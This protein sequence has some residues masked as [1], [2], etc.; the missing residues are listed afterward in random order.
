M[1]FGTII[2]CLMG[3]SIAGSA[4][5]DSAATGDSV[6]QLASSWKDQ[7]G[8][9]LQLGKFQG[10]PLIL[11]MIYT[12]CKDTC[13]LIVSD[14][15]KIEKALPS[16]VLAQVQFALF[17]FDTTR[18]TPDKLGRYAGAHGLDLKRWVLL[19]GSVDSVRELAAVLG[20]RYRK[21]R[22]GDYSHSSLITV[23][24]SNGVISYQQKGSRNSPDKGVSA[25]ENLLKPR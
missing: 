18:D 7:S 8:N 15:Q 23:L 9:E 6:Y 3:L 21:L 2:L 10:R 13:P 17:S 25:I 12:S 19:T 20:I 1:K 14:M 4:F 5:S 22:S 16:A 24:D 11:A